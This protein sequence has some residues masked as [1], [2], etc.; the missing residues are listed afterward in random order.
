MSVPAQTR[1]ARVYLVLL[2]LRHRAGVVT[3]R[4]VGARQC[5]W[6]AGKPVHATRGPVF[7][8]VAQ[9]VRARP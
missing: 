5:P 3:W 7:G 2:R 8:R 4:Q 9:V 1:S 6:C